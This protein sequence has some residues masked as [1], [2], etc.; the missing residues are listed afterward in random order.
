MLVF[1]SEA[2]AYLT[3]PGQILARVGRDDG[4]GQVQVN[5]VAQC[6]CALNHEGHGRAVVIHDFACPLLAIALVC[7]SEGE[8]RAVADHP[9]ISRASPLPDTHR[10][11][12]HDVGQARLGQCDRRREPRVT[13]ADDQSGAGR[14]V[15]RPLAVLRLGFFPPERRCLH[16]L[17]SRFINFGIPNWTKARRLRAAWRNRPS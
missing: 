3:Q 14:L 6:G 2:T 15:E 16:E 7:L 1:G 10:I 13:G 17:S 9:S 12:D 4:A 8:F 11:D 5:R